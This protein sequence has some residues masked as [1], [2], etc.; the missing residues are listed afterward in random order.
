[1]VAKYCG[2]CDRL[3]VRQGWITNRREA[4]FSVRG[5]SPVEATG[6]TQSSQRK[7]GLLPFLPSFLTFIHER[8]SQ[9][10]VKTPLSSV[11]ASKRP[12]LLL[13]WLGII[14]SVNFLSVTCFYPPF[15]IA[16]FEANF[17][18]D[19]IFAFF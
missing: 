4:A 5:W 2:S 3:F 10:S 11:Q 14:L 18:P 19:F 17:L 15:C 9:K 8:G 16:T 6:A 12:L 7:K 1:M 13:R